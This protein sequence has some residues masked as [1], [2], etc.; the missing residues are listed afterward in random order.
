MLPLAKLCRRGRP[1]RPSEESRMVTGHAAGTQ[2]GMHHVA[3]KGAVKAATT[4]S[5]RSCRAVTIPVNPLLLCHGQ[6]L[7]CT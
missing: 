1:F 4:S 3:A 2:I 7:A 5:H 6:Y